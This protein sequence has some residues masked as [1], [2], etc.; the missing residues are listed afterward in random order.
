MTGVQTCALPICPV[1]ASKV[2]QNIK[3]K[4]WEERVGGKLEF[5]PEPEEILK[6]SLEEIDK[7][8]DALKLR[9]YE[10][11]RFGTER[12]LMTMADR[13]RLESAARPHEGVK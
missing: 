12:K 7:K 13:R 5:I 9:K 2:V 10:P 6:R 3:T 4:V 11:G 1:E 8:R